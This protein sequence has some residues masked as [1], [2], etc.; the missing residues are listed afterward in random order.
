LLNRKLPSAHLP[1]PLFLLRHLFLQNLN[2][3]KALIK[4]AF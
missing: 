3:K 4:R 2:N 1:K